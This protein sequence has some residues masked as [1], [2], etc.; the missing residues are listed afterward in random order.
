MKYQNIVT[1]VILTI[2]ISA[3]SILMYC[4]Y[5]ADQRHRLLSKSIEYQIMA[6]RAAF[7]DRRKSDS[8]NAISNYLEAESERVDSLIPKFFKK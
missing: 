6:I 4:A 1:A 2:A 3:Y 7:E 8:L 5:L